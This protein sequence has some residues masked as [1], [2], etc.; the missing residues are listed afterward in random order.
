MTSMGLIITWVAAAFGLW[1][2]DKLV[3]H[4]ELRGDWKSFAL[5][6]A[7]VGVLN[8]LLGWL[9]F[10]ILGVATLGL[11]FLFGFVTRL[12]TSAIVLKIA[13]ALS[14]RF[15]IR[16]FVPALWGA[17]VLAVT[18]GLADFLR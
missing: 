5:I 17:V 11:G 7:V 3:P 18:G 8:F 10:V 4:F 15:T 16:G 9:I 12:V 6:A 2:A 13:D 14:D 1:I